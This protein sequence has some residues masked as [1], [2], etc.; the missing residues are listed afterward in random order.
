MVLNKKIV[1]IFFFIIVVNKS[2]ITSQILDFETEIFIDKII[3]EIKSVNN[4]NREIKFKII[5][6]KEINAFVD[7]NNIIY[8]T[9]GL[10]ANSPDY[11]ALLSVLAHEVGHIDKNHLNLRKS[12]IKK[13][14]NF[15]NISTLSVIAGSML[16]NN[17]EIIQGVVMSSASM[18]ERYIKFSKDQ[19]READL[20]SLETLKK[21]N[22]NSNSIIELLEIIEKTALNRGLSKNMQ[23]LSS[24]PYF[25]ERI[26]VINFVNK[27][28][29]IK[30]DQKTNNKFKFIQAKF[31]GYG[32][33]KELV[34]NLEG[35]HKLYAETIIDAKNGYLA[36]SLK[37]INYL[38]T[39][40]KNNI[41]LIETKADILFSHGYTNEAVEFYKIV[42]KKNL[43]N[44]YA[45]IRIF[46]N[47]NFN[48]LNKKDAGI[49][50]NENI[51]LLQIYYNNKNLLK[52]YYKL[53]KHNDMT[54]W[55]KFLE[56]WLNKNNI[57][58]FS[59]NKEL[60]KFRETEDKNL[61][62][63]IN[64]ILKNNL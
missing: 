37:K 30:F 28:L 24:H 32:D 4:I 16:A 1:L 8:I 5:S 44:K 58:N 27:N 25:E 52:I 9:S 6:N 21:L 20:Y 18:S 55:I 54:E 47:I 46:S 35:D 11:V 53:A 41:Y 48:K 38:I 14:N 64:L 57:D 61:R 2:A 7:E 43:E 10:I 42:L 51:N 49:L 33:N 3:S 36:K 15:K 59:I 62:D 17:T 23:R 19:E 50:F 31:I 45:Q 63:L 40:N 34:N 29:N 60:E 12:S 22:I 56:Y 26:E 13:I 39:T